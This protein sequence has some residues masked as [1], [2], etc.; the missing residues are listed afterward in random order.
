MNKSQ[1]II[2]NFLRISS[3]T[4]LLSLLKSACTDLGS[5]PSKLSI[6]LFKLAKLVFDTSVDVSMPVAPFKFA[7]VVKFQ[8]DPTQLSHF[9]QNVH[10][11]K[12]NIESCLYY[13]FHINPAIEY[14]TR[15]LLFEIQSIAF[16]PDYVFNSVWPVFC[17]LFLIKCFNK[18]FNLEATNKIC[19]WYSS[20]YF[21]NYRALFRP[22]WSATF[23]KNIFI[24]WF[25]CMITNFK[26]R[27]FVIMLNIGYKS[28]SNSKCSS[29]LYRVHFLHKLVSWSQNV[30]PY[31]YRIWGFFCLLSSFFDNSAVNISGMVFPKP[32]NHIIYWKNSVI[33]FRLSLI[34]CP[35]YDK[36]FWCHQQKIQKVSH[37]WHFIDHNSGSKYN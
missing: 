3:S 30:N 26:L 18:F 37:F 6:L 24:F 25:F 15:A 32:I 1:F 34:F 10:T 22:I 17:N 12:E 11:T 33:S 7:L 8:I 21:F 16:C 14:I 9:H 23:C 2:H 28:L 29:F 4:T 5:S 31:E 19:T 35:N 20:F 13:T 36:F 27:M